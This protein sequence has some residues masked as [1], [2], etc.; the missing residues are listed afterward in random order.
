ME[1]EQLV[2]YMRYIHAFVI[3]ILQ[4]ICTMQMPLFVSVVVLVKVYSSRF[5]QCSLRYNFSVL[6]P[7]LAA[8]FLSVNRPL[9]T[10][11]GDRVTMAVMEESLKEPSSGC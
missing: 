9:S 2:W 3:P 10:V 11:L 6:L 8:L 5:C 7:R 1:F 4:V